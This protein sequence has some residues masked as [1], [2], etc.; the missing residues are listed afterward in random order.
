MNKEIINKYKPEF[1]HWLNGGSLCIYRTDTKQFWEPTTIFNWDPENP[2]TVVYLINDEYVEFRKALAE[3]KTIQIYDVIKQHITNPNLDEYGW[4]DF[5]SFT[6]SS[7]FSKSVGCYRI[8][9]I[10]PIGLKLGDYVKLTS[11]THSVLRT[12]PSWFQIDGKNVTLHTDYDVPYINI[13]KGCHI[14]CLNELE[15]CQPK[16]NE[17]CWFWD[18]CT[19]HRPTLRQYDIFPEEYGE[20]NMFHDSEQNP[21]DFCEP[22]LNSLPSYL[23]DK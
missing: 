19:P 20:E 8:K 22:F 21:F 6:Q 3:G 16:P 18:K 23:K 1:E 5:K 10:K 4:R 12:Y 15:L 17:W 11:T 2:K 7:P 9:P 14:F 13:I